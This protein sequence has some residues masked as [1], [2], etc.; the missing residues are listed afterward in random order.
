[1]RQNFEIREDALTKGKFV[2]LKKSTKATKPALPVCT[3]EKLYDTLY[4]IYVALENPSMTAFWSELSSQY[5][6]IPQHLTECFIKG[7]KVN[8]ENKTSKASVSAKPIV[9][10]KFMTRVEADL[11]HMGD[12]GMI[13]TNTFVTHTIISPNGHGRL[14]SK[15]KRRIK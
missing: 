1:V 10:T 4:E 9:A 7:C 12:L 5:A 3:K 6:Y 2:L 13:P 15:Q 11:I 8:A 14:R